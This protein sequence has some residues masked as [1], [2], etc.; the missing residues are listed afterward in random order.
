MRQIRVPVGNLYQGDRRR[1]CLNSHREWNGGYGAWHVIWGRQL[2]NKSRGL[3]E[4]HFVL[5]RSI[6]STVVPHFP[7]AFRTKGI[8][9]RLAL[10][11][12]APVFGL[13]SIER[14]LL[15]GRLPIIGG[16]VKADPTIPQNRGFPG[17]CNFL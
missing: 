9:G 13:P 11:C 12:C 15:V 3:C 8:P 17:I 5:A 14:V 7:N 16:R 10:A 1:D 2:T 4:S 6:G